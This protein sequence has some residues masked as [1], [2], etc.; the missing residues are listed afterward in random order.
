MTGRTVYPT[1]E[2]LFGEKKLP[3]SETPLRMVKKERMA[4]FLSAVLLAA[5]AFIMLFIADE[6]GWLSFAS[7]CRLNP[8]P[9]SP[10]P[11]LQPLPLTLSEKAVARICLR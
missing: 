9:R 7:G 11:T 2:G 3:E 4:F 6:D 1:I 8:G 5:V 10:L